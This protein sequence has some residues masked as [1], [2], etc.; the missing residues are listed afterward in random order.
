MGSVYDTFCRNVALKDKEA[1]EL[2]IDIEEVISSINKLNSIRFHHTLKS[3]QDEVHSLKTL[4][5]T[6]GIGY[7]TI[8]NE[9]V[10]VKVSNSVLYTAKHLYGCSWPSWN[11]V[12][13]APGIYG[14]VRPL[15][16]EIAQ[17]LSELYAQQDSL[18]RYTSLDQYLNEI[19]P[20]MWLKLFGKPFSESGYSGI[21]YAHSDKASQYEHTWLDAGIPYYRGALMYML[22]YSCLMVR[23]KPESEWAAI[24]FYSLYK[25]LILECESL[26]E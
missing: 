8:G 22:T 13:E 5:D 2:L 21:I 17:N 24:E 11:R 9:I 3:M 16:Q 19:L 23:P 4:L 10:A 25:D 26:A 18:V 15:A 1:I 12:C 14:S 20:L 6:R 7:K